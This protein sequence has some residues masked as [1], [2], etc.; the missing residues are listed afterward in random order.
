MLITQTY[1]YNVIP[2]DLVR[3]FGKNGEINFR[4]ALN[5]PRKSVSWL[6]KVHQMRLF[7]SNSLILRTLRPLGGRFEQ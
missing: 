2:D 4:E 7:S 3:A 5:I 6:I 1:F